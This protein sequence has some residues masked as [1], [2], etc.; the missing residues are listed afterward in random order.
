MTGDEDGRPESE[1]VRA[2]VAAVPVNAREVRHVMEG[3]GAAA[4]AARAARRARAERRLLHPAEVRQ[5]GHHAAGREPVPALHARRASVGGG[6]GSPGRE[7]AAPERQ[8]DAEDQLRGVAGAQVEQAHGTAQQGPCSS[9]TLLISTTVVLP[10]P[11]RPLPSTRRPRACSLCPRSPYGLAPVRGLLQ[12]AQVA[13][14]RSQIGLACCE[15][16]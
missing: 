10:H 13:P 12:H 3:G 7:D 15:Q 11:V 6:D 5:A 2:P 8:P 9:T 4:A 14:G 1:A 16:A